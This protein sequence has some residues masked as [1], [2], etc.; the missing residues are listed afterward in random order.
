QDGTPNVTFGANS[1]SQVSDELNLQNTTLT[2]ELD[3]NS[4]SKTYLDA[5]NA[6]TIAIDTDS[7]EILIGLDSAAAI[8]GANGAVLI[9]GNGTD[10][11]ALESS[12]SSLLYDIQK[13]FENNNLVVKSHA[14]DIRE[15]ANDVGGNAGA[16]LEM[17][18]TDAEKEKLAYELLDEQTVS[19]AQRNVADFTMEAFASNATAQVQRISYMNQMMA[20]KLT[21]GS[22]TRDW[23][24]CYDPGD[25]CCLPG[26]MLW[27]SAYGLGGVTRQYD[28]F[29]RHDYDQWG[30]IIGADWQNDTTRF[31][32][33]YAYGQSE[34][35]GAATAMESDDH[36]FGAYLR[37]DSFVAGGYSLLGGNYSMS[38]Y[39]T[40]YRSAFDPSKAFHGDLDGSQ[41]SLYFEKGWEWDNAT[42]G[43]LNPYAALQYIGFQSDGFSLAETTLSDTEMDSLRSVLGLRWNRMFHL[44]TAS[45]N[46]NLGIAWHHEFADTEGTFL[47]SVGTYNPVVIHGNGGGRDWCE[48]TL[49][50]G[51]ILTDRL[52]LSADYYLFVNA[53]TSVHAGS[54]T[55]TWKF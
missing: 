42:G 19:D 32:L 29:A 8:N 23:E 25:C 11:S 54:A 18:R 30:T 5:S 33:Y 14:N 40:T 34:F 44:E 27:A 46:L 6:S 43:R 47:L 13:K 3:E 10:L 50:T 21:S 36:T 24:S 55:L 4:G 1:I 20:Q 51:L 12:V 53:P 7:T 45:V 52:T 28:G 16:V 31:G 41:G 38:N 49:G 22:W 37:W 26:A 2:F 17:G 15:V 48:F 35:A 9:A 39:E